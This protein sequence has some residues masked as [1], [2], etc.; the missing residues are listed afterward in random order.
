MKLTDTQFIRHCLKWRKKHKTE[1]DLLNWER[2]S[3]RVGPDGESWIRFSCGAVFGDSLQQQ[4][5][6]KCAW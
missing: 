5:I 6:G 4:V 2:L 1:D 3:D